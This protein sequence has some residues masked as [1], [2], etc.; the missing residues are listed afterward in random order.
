[1]DLQ[2]SED[3]IFYFEEPIPAPNKVYK[4]KVYWDSGGYRI[5]VDG[6]QLRLESRDTFPFEMAN[7]HYTGIDTLALHTGM[8]G[9]RLTR[10]QKQKKEKLPE[11]LPEPHLAYWG[12]F[13]LTD[14]SS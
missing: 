3:T 13:H 7:K 14:L 10:S 6:E 4:M 5:W 9:T 2:F 8:H 11:V 1:V 12:N